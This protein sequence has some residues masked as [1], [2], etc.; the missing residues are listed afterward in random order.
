[1]RRLRNLGAIFLAA[2]C[3]GCSASTQ[4]ETNKAADYIG[5]PKRLFVVEAMGH[6]IRGSIA[7]FQATFSQ[8]MSK[9]GVAVEF[10]DVPATSSP[11][12]LD[13]KETIAEKALLNQKAAKFKPDSILSL[14][15]TSYTQ[16]TNTNLNLTSISAMTYLITL[17]DVVTKR[18]VWKAEVKV[19]V[20]LS[21]DPGPQFATDIASRMTQDGV[22]RSCAPTAK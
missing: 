11:L 19:N 10:A 18:N 2:V 13:N 12:A 15:E 22:L 3:A 21:F 6:Q 7:S 16:H 1:M 9:C 8:A 4:I 5:Q 17:S 20:N 14:A